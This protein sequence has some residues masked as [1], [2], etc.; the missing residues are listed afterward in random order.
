MIQASVRRQ[1]DISATMAARLD[2]AASD[3]LWSDQAPWRSANMKNWWQPWVWAL[4]VAYS[5]FGLVS[6]S[7]N[8]WS[9]GWS[10]VRCALMM[11]TAL[12]A[13]YLLWRQ[14]LSVEEPEAKNGPKP[15]SQE[16]H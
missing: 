4:A 2:K 6:E 8:H 12:F 14:W 7:M 5:G 13:M 3:R 15:A 16:S 9:F 1:S 10:V 11:T